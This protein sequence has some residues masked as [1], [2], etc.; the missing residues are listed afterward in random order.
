M[1]E[2]WR[3]I[4]GFI[5]FKASDLGRIK[6]KKGEIL[7]QGINNTG[8]NRV[9]VLGKRYLVHRL[10]ALAFIDN[11]EN[12]RT[13]NHKNGIKT[14]NR[15]I[16]LEWATDKENL[17]HA[18]DTGLRTMTKG[19]DNKLSKC[20]AQYDLDNRL[21]NFFGSIQEAKRKT[22]ILHISEVCNGYRK[23]A[24]G[25]KWGFYDF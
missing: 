9:S 12:K 3:Y 5:G 25:Y 8:Y 2:V 16:N 24:G 14:D 15:L 20:V 21:I 1:G 6:N 4:P 17:K 22:G 13:I 10:I 11:P 18:L 7:Y 19:F 23:T